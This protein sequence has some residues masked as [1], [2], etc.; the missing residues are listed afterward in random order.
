VDYHHQGC[1]V[2]ANPLGYAHKNE[3]LTF[4]AHCVVTVKSE[5]S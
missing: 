4:R 3:Q 2:V 5:T 1:R